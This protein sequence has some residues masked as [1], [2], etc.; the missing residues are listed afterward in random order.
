MKVFYGGLLIGHFAGASGLPPVRG[1]VFRVP[2][3]PTLSASHFPFSEGLA[4]IEFDIVNCLLLGF[5][6]RAGFIQEWACEL[7]ADPWLAPR[8]PGW[9]S[10]ESGI[11]G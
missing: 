10:E 4:D 5:R 8:L 11:A 7:L 3:R 1:Y 9:R 6:D 2:L